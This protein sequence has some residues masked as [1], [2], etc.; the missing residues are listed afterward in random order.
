MRGYFSN[1]FRGFMFKGKSLLEYTNKHKNVFLTNIKRM[2]KE[3]ILLLFSNCNKCGSEDKK[4]FK[5]E[6]SIEILKALGLITNIEE[7]QKI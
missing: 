7:Y 1:G 4:I 5:D 2:T 3:K 6:E